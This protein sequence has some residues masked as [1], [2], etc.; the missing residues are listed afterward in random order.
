[1]KTKMLLILIILILTC[2]SAISVEATQIP[3]SAQRLSKTGYSF[4]FVKINEIEFVNEYMNQY[5]L[6]S[7]QIKNTGDE[8]T[9]SVSELVGI[10]GEMYRHSKPNKIVGDWG[11][12]S[13]VW[14]PWEKNEIKSIPII[15][16][17]IKKTIF[18]GVFHINAKMELLID[19][20]FF[21]YPVIDNDYFI[22][23]RHI[24]PKNLS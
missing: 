11:E 12:A 7:A 24:F 4:A 21:Y 6:I 8:I 9:N 17:Q 1:M 23:G 20:H 19:S 16:F 10:F 5:W 14:V 22:F 18:P 3:L 13:S 15:H 2:S